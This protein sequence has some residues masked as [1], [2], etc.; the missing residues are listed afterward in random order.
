MSDPAISYQS[1]LDSYPREQRELLNI[2]EDFQTRYRYLPE[3]ALRAA[4]VHLALPLSR[5]FSVASFYRALSLKPKGE[6]LV[7]VCCGTA[8][9]LRGAPLLIE[10]LEEGLGVKLGETDSA[11]RFTLESV[12][13]LGACALAPVVTVDSTV[14]GKLTQTSVKKLKI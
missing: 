1:V 3:E 7:R 12:N 5:V 11:G 13:C 10:A 4:A 8:C 2:L 6:K 14:H 9:H